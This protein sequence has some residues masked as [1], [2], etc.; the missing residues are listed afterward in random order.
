MKA[1]SPILDPATSSV[2]LREQDMYRALA[3]DTRS[4]WQSGIAPRVTIDA[5]AWDRPGTN[6][7]FTVVATNADGLGYYEVWQHD[8]TSST[9]EY[10]SPRS[11]V[12]LDCDVRTWTVNGYYVFEV[13]S[14][15]GQSTLSVV[16]RGIPTAAFTPWTT[17][18]IPS[19]TIGVGATPTSYPITLTNGWTNY[20][21]W[22]PAKATLW[23]NG[24]LEI[25][26]LVQHAASGVPSQIGYLPNG[27]KPSQYHM[28]FGYLSGEPCRVDVQTDGYI[29][30]IER[31]KPGSTTNPG[32]VGFYGNIFLKGA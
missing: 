17:D 10:P 2:Y 31:N 22:T 8:I 9:G 6:L 7:H 29:A 30:L 20:A 23:S 19:R 18:A 14:G 21:G 26:G 28:L 24:E 1:I 4:Y 25:V 15:E 32:Y 11:V 12:W 5:R 3:P 16:V 13:W 27:W